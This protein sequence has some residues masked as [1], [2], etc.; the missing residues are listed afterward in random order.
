MRGR[1]RPVGNAA[2]LLEA[3]GDGAGTPRQEGVGPAHHGVLLVQDRRHAQ[4]LAGEH[5]RHGGV[6]AETHDRGRVDPPDLLGC[7]REAAAERQHGA[8]A[9][10]HRAAGRGRRGDGDDLGGRK[11]ARNRVDP[12][13]G[14]EHHPDSAGAQRVGEALGREQVAAGAARAEHDGG[15][16][17][18][19]RITPATVAGAVPGGFWLRIVVRGRLRVSATR[20]P[21]PSASEISD[22]PP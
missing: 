22:E 6:A 16:E 10:Q 13:V 21:M 3:G 18:R 5:R 17:H 7:H 1:A 20:K 4:D 12:R 19:H 15:R 9:A 2:H 8:R 11:L 14:G